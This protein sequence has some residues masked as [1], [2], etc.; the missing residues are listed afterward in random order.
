M[1]KVELKK[2]VVEEISELLNGAATAVVVDYRGLTV[3]EDTEL[4]KQ[5]KRSWCCIQSI[6]E[7]YD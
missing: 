2:P 7:H 5:F 3:A 1:A 6:Q 4:R